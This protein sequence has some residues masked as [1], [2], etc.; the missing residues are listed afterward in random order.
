MVEPIKAPADVK[1]AA[2]VPAATPEPAK[3]AQPTPQAVTPAVTPS[4]PTDVKPEPATVPLPVLLEERSK[5]QQLE[6]ELAQLKQ[7]SQASQQ[8]TAPV[9]Q[10]YDPQA[11]LEK[12]WETDPRKAVEATIM[13]N[14]DWRDR[15]DASLNIQADQLAMKYPD[16][17][18]FRSATL[19]YVRSLPIHQRNAPGILDAAYFM[20][21]GQ[22]VDVLLQQRENEL[23]ER[24]RRGDLAAAQLLQPAGSFSAP[25]TPTTSVTLTSEQIRVAEA[26]GL[27]PEAYASQLRIKNV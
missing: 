21:K 3:P 20:V 16:F 6:T 15:V 26:M 4:K 18:N 8:P 23:L 27:S 12:L 7:L 11:E 14:M 9:Q 17:N 2:T 10:G 5:R 19:G 22:N 24:Y 1:P 25:S 13:M